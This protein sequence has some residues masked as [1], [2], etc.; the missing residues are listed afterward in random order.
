MH[1]KNK[2][3]YNTPRLEKVKVQKL[4]LGGSSPSNNENSQKYVGP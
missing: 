1:K 3:E 2:K 4:T